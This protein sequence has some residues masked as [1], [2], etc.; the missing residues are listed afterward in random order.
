M[1]SGKVSK[2]D[3]EMQSNALI[4]T[5]ERTGQKEDNLLLTIPH[6]ILGN[7]DPHICN[8]TIL[9]D[10]KKV[11]YSRTSDDV[12]TGFEIPLP[13]NASKIQIFPIIII[14]IEIPEGASKP[15]NTEFFTPEIINVSQGSPVVW[16]NNDVEI[17]TV[18]SGLPDTGRSAGTLFDSKSFASGRTFEYTFRQ[19]G[20]FD[21][22]CTLH[23]FMTGKV[24]V[25]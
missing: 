24:V 8:F 13:A 20:T 1:N 3:P 10:G 11:N 21:Y 7:G 4:L 23:P 25:N 15:T 6:A 14:N 9:V 22:F 2:I 17:H 16:T 12:E 18:T 5:L 19:K